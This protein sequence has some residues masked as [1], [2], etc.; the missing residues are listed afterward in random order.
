VSLNSPHSS[1]CSW[2]KLLN[3]KGKDVI[4][5]S[6]QWWGTSVTQQ[7]RKVGGGSVRAGI[8]HLLQFNKTIHLEG[9]GGKK[10]VTKK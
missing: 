8:D 9:G 5:Q 2:E 7:S 3:G 4:K 10:G 6:G 1:G